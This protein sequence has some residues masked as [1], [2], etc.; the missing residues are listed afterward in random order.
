MLACKYCKAPL[1]WA[2]RYCPFCGEQQTVVGV[3]AQPPSPVAEPLPLPPQA[4]PADPIERPR[5]EDPAQRM[6]TFAAATGPVAE[7]EFVEPVDEETDALFW[8]APA[9]RAAAR[10]RWLW[11]V[12][13]GLGLLGLGGWYQYPNLEF[14]PMVPIPAGSFSMG[15]QPGE[16]RKCDYWEKP[17]HRVRVAAFELGRQEVTFDEWDTCVAERGCGQ[18]P[19]DAGWGRGKRPVINVSWDDAQ[20]Y[21][22]WLSH[23]TGKAYRLPTEAEWEYVA[24]AGTVTAFSTGNCISTSQANYNDNVAY[25]GCGAK[26]GVSLGK[27]QPVGSYRANPWGLRDLQGNVWEWVQDC[28]HASYTS[29]PADGSSWRNACSDGRRRVLRG[30]SWYDDAQNQRSANR[31]RAFSTD[32]AASVGFRVARSLAR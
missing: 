23:K 20:Q 8:D 24:R 4:G 29:A 28:W 6:P 18:K 31:S 12:L 22:T 3:S 19:D 15:C 14:R 13:F 17:A 5:D 11:P 10:R 7:P 2:T 21:V 9:P 1:G 26:T 25:P 16:K 32:R 30:G 27:S